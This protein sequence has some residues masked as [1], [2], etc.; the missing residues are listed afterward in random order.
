MKPIDI[1]DPI[2]ENSSYDFSFDCI[3]IIYN[4]LLPSDVK[5]YI[6]LTS[7]RSAPVYI[8]N[9]NGTVTAGLALNG[10][11]VTL[12]MSPDDNEIIA[13]PTDEGYFEAHTI[14]FEMFY[15]SGVDKFYVEFRAKIQNFRVVS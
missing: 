8:N 7:D 3:D 4:D 13:A 6:Y 12:H 9:R 2:P 1:I 5:V 14:L 10:T 11:T 15:N